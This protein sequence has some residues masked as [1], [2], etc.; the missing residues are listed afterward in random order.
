M[1]IKSIS[2]NGL[3]GKVDSLVEASTIVPRPTIFKVADGST[4]AQL[5]I[6]KNDGTLPTYVDWG[7]GDYTLSHHHDYASPTSGTVITAIFD[8]NY[9]GS[10]NHYSIEE[11]RQFGYCSDTGRNNQLASA[12]P[13]GSYAATSGGGQRA[14]SSFQNL[15]QQGAAA[16]ATLNIE[17]LTNMEEMFSETGRYNAPFNQDIGHWDVSQVENMHRM[18]YRIDDFN[19]DISSW[20]VSNVTNM[21]WMFF[22]CSSFNQDLSSWCVSNIASAPTYFDYAADSWTLPRPVWGTCP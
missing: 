20:D 7:D 9:E 11:I 4:Y 13:T 22:L 17:N 12:K 8:W 16:I 15:S 21:D 2:N 1:A 3:V 18:F 5:P 10:T 6:T 19:Q 14:F